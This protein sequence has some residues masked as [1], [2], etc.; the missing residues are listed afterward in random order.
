MKNV[1]YIILL[2]AILFCCSP[3]NQTEPKL[4]VA[5]DKMNVLYIGVDNPLT[6]AISD[7]PNE[8]IRVTISQG[9]IKK[10]E[11][12]GKYIARVN[13]P[14]IASIE[15][16]S[17]KN[18]GKTKKLGTTNF[19]VK[20][21]PNPY[22]TIF[23]RNGGEIKKEVLLKQKEIKAVL[24]TVFDLGKFIVTE[25]SFVTYIGADLI[26]T[27]VRGNRLSDKIKL[28]IKHTKRDN[29]VYFEKIK[30]KGPDDVVIK[31]PTLVFEIK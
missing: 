15:V 8:N 29:E 18:K 1:F 24:P 28:M 7:I 6:L 14:G 5:A 30:A 10:N 3:K 17:K 31:L 25:Y 22:A 16:F 27:K 11:S 21:I 2:T 9:S 23:N 19:R 20:K 12:K 4:S 26:E 13:N